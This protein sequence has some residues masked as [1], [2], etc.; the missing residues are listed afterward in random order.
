MVPQKRYK[1]HTSSDR[2]RYVDEDHFEESIHFYMQKPDEA[3]IPLRDTMHGRFAR[4]VARDEPMFRERGSSISV[5]LNVSLAPHGLPVLPTCQCIGPD[6]VTIPVAW[7]STLESP[8]PHQGFL[9]PPWAYHPYET[10]E[11][12][13]QVCRPLHFRTHNFES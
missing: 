9:Q 8:D 2:R 3:G 4:L 6:D 12:C 7:L 13:G 5:R 1:P 10:G 11:E